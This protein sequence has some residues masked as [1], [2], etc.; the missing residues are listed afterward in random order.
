MIRV[1]PTI[2]FAICCQSTALAGII[3][4]DTTLCTSFD[5]SEGYAGWQFSGMLQRQLVPAEGENSNFIRITDRLGPVSAG[6][7]PPVFHGDWSLWNERGFVQFDIKIEPSNP[8]DTL[9]SGYPVLLL[10]GPGGSAQINAWPS[11]L[12]SA[13][14]QWQRLSFALNEADWTM[15]SGDWAALMQ[16]VTRVQVTLEFIYG[17]EIVW[18]D[19]FCL[20][21]PALELLTGKPTEDDIR[22]FPNPAFERKITISSTAPSL[23]GSLSVWDIHGRRIVYVADQELNGYEWDGGSLPAGT[24]FLLIQQSGRQVPVKVI[25]Q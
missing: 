25:F 12:L 15:L 21:R 17:S 24:Y 9:L 20:H 10:S 2:V 6:I 7:A 22:V 16:H 5:M 19:N 13:I 3:S 8:A 14:G 4:G 23:A 11:D 1:L 18:F